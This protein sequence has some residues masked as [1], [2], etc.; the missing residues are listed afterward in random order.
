MKIMKQ[1]RTNTKNKTKR[2]K[3]KQ[4]Q[5]KELSETQIHIDTQKKCFNIR[6]KISV[7]LDTRYVGGSPNISFDEHRNIVT[8]IAVSKKNF[9]KKTNTRASEYP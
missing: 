6:Q 7:Y 2:N 9:G 4:H 3:T 5:E 1:L 8:T